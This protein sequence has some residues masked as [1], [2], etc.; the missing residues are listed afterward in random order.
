M[1]QLMVKIQAG[2]YTPI[3]ADCYSE[4]MRNL[5]TS[6]LCYDKEK[7]PY[8]ATVMSNPFVV[9]H[10][11]RVAEEFSKAPPEVKIPDMPARPMLKR[12]RPGGDQ[13]DLRVLMSAGGQKP[14]EDAKADQVV[15]SADPGKQASS[16]HQ[17]VAVNPPSGLVVATGQE[18]PMKGVSQQQQPLPPKITAPAP[19]PAPAP[20][21]E[22]LDP[23]NPIMI[24]RANLAKMQGGG[25]S[26]IQ[27]GNVKGGDKKLVPPKEQAK[28]ATSTQLQ[29]NQ[30]NP[31]PPHVQIVV[32]QHQ[33]AQP[34]HGTSSTLEGARNAG[35]SQDAEQIQMNPLYPPLQFPV[36]NEE[37]TSII[38]E[39]LKQLKSAS[40][41]I[42]K[43]IQPAE[44]NPDVQRARSPLPQGVAKEY[45]NPTQDQAAQG[46]I[47]EQI[48]R[49]VGKLHRRASIARPEMLPKNICS[50][51]HEQDWKQ[52]N[53]MFD[54][55]QEDRNVVD[56]R[57]EMDMRHFLKFIKRKFMSIFVADPDDDVNAPLPG[58]DNRSIRISLDG[59]GRRMGSAERGIRRLGSAEQ[60]ARKIG[61]A[62]QGVRK[63]TSAE[64]EI[65]TSDMAVHRRSSSTGAVPAGPII[66]ETND[67]QSL[68]P[69]M[70]LKVN[71]SHSQG[72]LPTNLL[73]MP[74]D[75]RGPLATDRSIS[76][77][78][79]DLPTK[80]IGTITSTPES[81]R[82]TEALTFLFQHHT[83][84][85]IHFDA[86]ASPKL[87]SQDRN[88]LPSH[89]PKSISKQEMSTIPR[90][91]CGPQILQ[92]PLRSADQRTLTQSHS[93]NIV[94]SAIMTP[95]VGSRRVSAQ[96]SYQGPSPTKSLNS[97]PSIPESEVIPQK[98]PKSTRLDPSA[99]VPESANATPHAIT[100]QLLPRND[101]ATKRIEEPDYVPGYQ[102]PG[103]HPHSHV[104]RSQEIHDTRSS[105]IAP[106]PQ[107][108][109]SSGPNSR[110]VLG[111]ISVADV[112]KMSAIAKEGGDGII[113]SVAD[114]PLLNQKG[115]G[116]SEVIRREYVS[117]DDHAD[118]GDI[119]K[120]P[121]RNRAGRHSV[122]PSGDRMMKGQGLGTSPAPSP[123]PALRFAPSPAPS[124]PSPSPVN[125]GSIAPT[126]L[127]PIGSLI[128]RYSP[129][130]SHTELAG[131]SNQQRVV[132]SNHH[133]HV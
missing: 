69:N 33:E 47:A 23:N 5:V 80:T 113:D 50:E 36:V 27:Q 106:M 94:S 115:F 4:S 7:R 51:K 87:T 112:A 92:H 100:H 98:E 109:R 65:R 54:L 114:P 108:R 83:D 118:S 75:A 34:A 126:A 103:P 81:I 130:P 46:E 68:V 67:R 125:D 60:G 74:N 76:K 72:N 25:N 117:K 77:F 59:V 43:D 86:G 132:R 29:P 88:G 12:N 35:G 42:P 58:Y 70:A 16:Q 61:S 66:I 121:R 93:A 102:S 40:N 22:D 119:K 26:A 122:S 116:H 78:I 101:F 129:A 3:P 19:A 55:E 30:Q 64:M 133:G 18:A 85:L 110:D 6:L 104:P 105:H 21:E 14:P 20:K 38:L 62:E 49:H 63:P 107:G 9:E 111:P 123:S 120:A 95:L 39:Q 15:P 24:F 11:G 28:K 90:T 1:I 13:P 97:S 37:R 32:D 52:S 91:P 31:N 124:N 131:S 10:V 99:T 127:P 82:R 48:K 41:L 53:Q 96:Q 128:P 73:G 2:K 57:E 89:F 56:D 79:E 17:S 8:M 44:P 71:E 84:P 45:E